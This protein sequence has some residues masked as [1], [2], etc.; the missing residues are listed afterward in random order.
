MATA[1]LVRHGRTTANSD[2][3]LAGRSRG[4]AL[5]E[6][7]RAQAAAAGERLA[8][9]PLAMLATS[10]LRRCRQTAA[11]IL[12]AREPR[13][14]APVRA[15]TERGLLEC[16]Y[17]E[18]QGQ[19]LRALAKHPL[20][21]VV[22]VQPSAVTFPAGE[23]LP[24]MS[25]RVVAAVRGRDAEVTE[26]DGPEACW[27]AVSHAD[28]I[29]AVVADALGMHLDLFQRL[30]VDPGSVTVI[31]YGTPRPFVVALNTQ[32]G[33]LG[34]LAPPPRRRRRRG[35]AARSG[36]DAV[37]GGV[38]GGVVGGGAGPVPPPA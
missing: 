36:A 33:D 14:S 28:P 17:G 20:W 5:D 25:A 4:V 34:W 38:G 13:G 11:A 1:I 32:A 12:A 15:V 10:P 22:Q 30:V 21:P 6:V 7:G 8:G 9:L 24:G 26:R 19:S 31:R 18:W 2:G 35:G 3:V 37:V 27:V 29:K 23:S 16:D